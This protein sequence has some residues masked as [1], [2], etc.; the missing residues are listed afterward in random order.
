MALNIK[1]EVVAYGTTITLDCIVR[2]V[3]IRGSK[4]EIIADC[5]FTNNGNIIDTKSYLFTPSLDGDNF[6]KQGYFYL[7]TLPEY[8]DAVDC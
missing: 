2:I 8:A 7:K 5:D 4:N 3:N 6:I 1:K